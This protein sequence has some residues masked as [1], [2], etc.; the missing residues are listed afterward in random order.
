MDGAVVA[1]HLGQGLALRG[2]VQA[3]D[4]VGAARRHERLGAVAVDADRAL[5]RAP[6]KQ[7]VCV[8]G[9][10]VF[11]LKSF[12]FI[13]CLRVDLERTPLPIRR[14]GCSSKEVV[15]EGPRRVSPSIVPGDVHGKP[16]SPLQR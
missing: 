2:V 12:V 9:G 14:P 4:A 16:R 3:D 7:S 6:K 15:P 5:A 10:K 1:L 8:D 13:T 11:P